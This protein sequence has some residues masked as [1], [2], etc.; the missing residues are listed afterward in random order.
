MSIMTRDEDKDKTNSFPYTSRTNST[1]KDKKYILVYAEDFHFLISHA[2]WFVTHIYEHYTFEPSKFK[3][4]F[5]IN[6]KWRQKV[7]LS[8]E[9]DFFKLLNNSNFG[10]DCRNNIDNCILESLHND[11]TEISYIK[12]YTTIFK[13]DT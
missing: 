6:Q 3:R 9:R 4:D 13:D 2:C 11:F 10:I 7:I 5:I 8:V 12:K 1:L